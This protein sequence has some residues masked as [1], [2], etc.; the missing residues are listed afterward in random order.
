MTPR[1]L[2]SLALLV[3]VARSSAADPTGTPAAPAKTAPA[4]ITPAPAP[5]A[6][7][8]AAAAPGADSTV[9]P[10]ASFDTFRL[11]TERNIFN[12]NRTGR[13]ERT[14]EEAPP[15]VDVISLV[16][17][18]DSDKG[19]RAFFDGSTSGYRKAL[20][21]GE[22]IDQ[23]KLT[24]IAPNVVELEREGKMLS[25]RVGQQLRR[26]EGA[27]WTL[28]GEEIAQREA[29]AQARAA[30]VSTEIP[31]GVS[32]LERRLRERRQKESKN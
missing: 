13:R 10:S 9:A 4:A 2:L 12:P 22:S 27:E 21:V 15:R 5:A 1:S 28:V 20:R 30:T 17:T 3:G 25:M 7:A 24:Q 11:I 19:V 16:G 32:D 6:R 23:F 26:P 14:V 29:Q 18:M 8:P 31:A